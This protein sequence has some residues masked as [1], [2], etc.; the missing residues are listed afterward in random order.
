[1]KR[2]FLAKLIAASLVCTSVFGVSTFAAEENTFTVETE[3]DGS[4]VVLENS[5]SG[6]DIDI[7]ANRE[8]TITG[9]NIKGKDINV[10]GKIKLKN[11]N[12]V[13]IDEYKVTTVSDNAFANSSYESIKL[14][15]SVTTIKAKAFAGNTALKTVNIPASVTDIAEDA[16]EGA[17]NVVIRCSKNSQ[18]KAFA[19]ANGIRYELVDEQVLQSENEKAE[20]E[21]ESNGSNGSNGSGESSGEKETASQNST[22]SGDEKAD[23][24][25]NKATS[26]KTVELGSGY[27]LTYNSKIP[28]A[29]KKYSLSNFGTMT[30]SAN[31]QKYEVSKIKVNK[32]KKTFQIIKLAGADK[33]AVK[34]VKKLTKGAKAVSYEVY[35]YNVSS[36]D[37]VSCK[38]N[39]KG[40]LK[41]VMITLNGKK[42][43]AKKTEYD[44]TE[45]AKT[46]VFKGENLTG[47]YI[48]K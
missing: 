14:P 21:S 43:K 4:V 25:S 44:Y 13:I 29:G 32:K 17:S 3:A 38:F 37:A 34:E 47:S 16:F 48:V 11:S 27:Y 9:C 36:N 2:S 22:V 41:K 1:M 10:P 39:K 23:V 19:E 46:V 12:G 5:K 40:E 45:A 7:S 33:A 18:A 30:V 31:G 15:N 26:V 6:F 42:Y 8:V 20:E 28:F 35:A 24:S